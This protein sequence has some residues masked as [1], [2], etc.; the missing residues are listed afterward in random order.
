MKTIFFCTVFLL[1]SVCS[2][3]FGDILLDSAFGFNGYFS[4]EDG[5]PLWVFLEN[6][7]ADFSG[8][9]RIQQQKRALSE[10]SPPLYSEVCVIRK[11]ERKRFYFTISLT[12]GYSPLIIQAMDNGEMLWQSIAEVLYQKQIEPFILDMTSGSRIPAEL[13]TGTE[14]VRT[15][16]PMGRLLPKHWSGYGSIRAV[17]TDSA[18]YTSLPHEEK[19]A[20]HIFTAFGGRIIF[21]PGP[22]LL[23][24]PP[25]EDPLFIGE[26]QNPPVK[27]DSTPQIPVSG[28][29]GAAPLISYGN[30]P[31]V[32]GK[33]V[34]KGFVYYAD[35][36]AAEDI[37]GA[38][39]ISA[40]WH[41]LI[42]VPVSISP[43]GGSSLYS[44]N[45]IE[46]SLLTS[47]GLNPYFEI[48]GSGY[49]AILY[50]TCLF[51]LCLSLVLCYVRI[52][53]LHG[54][55]AP[56]F[57]FL[58]ALLG[59]AGTHFLLARNLYEGNLM[60][61][62][63]SLIEMVDED[64]AIVHSSKMLLSTQPGTARIFSG[65]GAWISPVHSASPH[66]FNSR[67][68]DMTA[69]MN[70]WQIIRLRSKTPGALKISASVRGN[71]L[72]IE[73]ETDLVLID[74]MFVQGD[75]IRSF[76]RI[77]PFQ[78][79]EIL[80]DTAAAS[81]SEYQDRLKKIVYS[82]VRGMIR[83]EADA[84]PA[85]YYLCSA[86]NLDEYLTAD[87]TAWVHRG[88]AVIVCPV[89]KLPA[90]GDIHAAFD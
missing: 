25:E 59:I 90:E 52:P 34:G 44:F 2:A 33:S 76:G 17:I 16:K 66:T 10:E 30:V 79:K 64:M 48:P 13:N 4:G 89:R 80:L 78:K 46:R 31:L 58:A 3:L 45:E 6:T 63:I 24:S 5:I 75:E 42:T 39:E 19:K 61:L 54:W 86:E 88:I 70:P 82:H 29:S 1:F 41:D 68:T 8:H 72:E 18:A 37:R 69:A 74:S 71:T 7:G 62:E 55:L 26:F 28:R 12:E 73:N 40:I 32:T 23:S 35:I 51:L 38:P 67:S 49:L 11:G 84:D 27:K 65:P 77:S 20:L 60:D 53:I 57:I 43:F 21:L 85:A 22:P 56:V 50:G 87:S 9:L 15:V 81:Y 36:D 47:V 83:R 14:S